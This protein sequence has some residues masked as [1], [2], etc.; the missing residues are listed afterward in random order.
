MGPNRE[1]GPAWP[2]HA[3][4]FK[5][6]LCHGNLLH[7]C[8]S[9]LSHIALCTCGKF[10]VGRSMTYKVFL[11]ATLPPV[12]IGLT[13]KCP[14]FKYQYSSICPLSLGLLLSSP[15][16]S[17]QTRLF[18]NI[19][20]GRNLPEDSPLT[21]VS[22]DVLSALAYSRGT[23]THGGDCSTNVTLTPWKSRNSSGYP[24]KYPHADAFQPPG[25]VEISKPRDAA[26]C[27]LSP[28]TSYIQQV[29]EICMNLP[30]WIACPSKS[31][32]VSWKC[33]GRPA[34]TRSSKIKGH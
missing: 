18:R 26:L 1:A 16:L 11:W 24:S 10:A 15:E 4:T 32:P 25:E 28:A 14:H 6:R 20:V 27:L 13:H 29:F 17:V 23:T 8:S 21:S 31:P 3:V 22:H 7:A 5:W 2:L 33:T 12:L 34:P 19:T 9:S 30:N